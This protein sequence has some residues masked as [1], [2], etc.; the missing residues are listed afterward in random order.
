MMTSEAKFA[1]LWHREV[2]ASLYILYIYIDTRLLD[3]EIERSC[4]T[5]TFFIYRNQ[6]VYLFYLLI[7]FAAE[8]CRH[9]KAVRE[10]SLLLVIDDEL[11]KR[12]GAGSLRRDALEKHPWLASRHLSTT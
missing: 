6:E 1:L 7:V 10:A 12:R 5:T 4:T 2:Q 3:T 8:R 11:V 9:R